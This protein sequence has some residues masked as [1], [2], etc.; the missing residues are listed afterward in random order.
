MKTARLLQTWSWKPETEGTGDSEVC[1][2][3]L[4]ERCQFMAYHRIN[5]WIRSEASCTSKAPPLSEHYT[6]DPSL[7]TGF[8]RGFYFQIT[9]GALG[10]TVRLLSTDCYLLEKNDILHRALQTQQSG[11]FWIVLRQAFFPL[12]F[13]VLLSAWRSSCTVL[14]SLRSCC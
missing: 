3:H 9:A 8:W 7:S 2:F 12:C 11:L 4:Q 1:S 13:C 6:G 14:Q 10:A 5:V